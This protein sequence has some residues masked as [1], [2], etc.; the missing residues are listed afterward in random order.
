[1]ILTITA[2]AVCIN[3][4]VA[5]AKSYYTNT[6]ANYVQEYATI[7]RYEAVRNRYKGW[8]YTTYYEYRADGMV[9]SGICQR[10][11]YDEEEAKAQVGTK[12][13]I[14]VDHSLKYHTTSLKSSIVPIWIAGALSLVFF[15]VFIN[16]FVRE[17]IYIVRWK[18]YK[19]AYKPEK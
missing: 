18:K 9:Y 3:I 11:I 13:R 1:M 5:S 7:V 8:S 6:H 10:L 2:C 12:M 19:Q 15:A 14:Y 4:S 17:I 16:S